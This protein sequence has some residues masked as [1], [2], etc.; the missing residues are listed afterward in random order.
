MGN[1]SKRRGSVSIIERV[2]ESDALHLASAA[3]LREFAD[4][5]EARNN[6]QV[7]VGRRESDRGE[8]IEIFVTYGHVQRSGA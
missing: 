4:W 2:A 6:Y 7:L 5:L 1:Q 3:E 8:Q